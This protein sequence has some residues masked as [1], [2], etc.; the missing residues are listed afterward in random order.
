METMQIVLYIIIIIGILSLYFV[1]VYNNIKVQIL[2]INAV[3]SEIDESLRQKYDLVLKLASEIKKNDK[4]SK[5][6]EKTETIKD[7]KLSSFEFER[8]LLEIENEIYVLKNDNTKLS[9]NN[10]F[11]ELWHDMI[12][13]NTKINAHKKYYNESTSIYNELITKFPSK[14]LSIILR[15]DEKN[16]FDG[17]NMY[18]KNIKDFKI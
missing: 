17:K 4:N 6:L 11:N 18:D 3:E 12:N 7:E 13:L 10:S 5:I 14:I 8:K 9:K 15:L 16:Y 1:K 2:K